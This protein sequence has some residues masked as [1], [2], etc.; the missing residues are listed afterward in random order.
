MPKRAVLSTAEL[1]SSDDEDPPPISNIRVIQRP[2]DKERIAD[3]LIRPCTLV[4]WRSE[5]GTEFMAKLDLIGKRPRE[6][7]DKMSKRTLQTLTVNTLLQLPEWAINRQ[8]LNNRLFSTQR[9]RGAQ[10][11]KLFTLVTCSPRLIMPSS[12]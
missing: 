1:V 8:V 12:V 11:A 10:Q 7:T 5:E 2:E 9:L 6:P 3:N 4:P